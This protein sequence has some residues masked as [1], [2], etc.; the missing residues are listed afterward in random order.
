MQ[1]G[2]ILVQVLAIFTAIGAVLT[3]I[4]MIGPQ[5][6]A[7]STAVTFGLAQVLAILVDRAIVLLQIGPVIGYSLGIPGLLVGTQSVQVLATLAI[8]LV[9]RTPILADGLIVLTQVGSILTSILAVLAQVATILAQIASIL[10]DRLL[11][12]ANG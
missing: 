9:E 6:A 7:V 3:F 8:G 1:L 5:I 12:L 4:A 11:V 10:T 2:F